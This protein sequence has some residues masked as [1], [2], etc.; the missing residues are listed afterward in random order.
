MY[1]YTSLGAAEWKTKMLKTKKPQKYLFK[2]LSAERQGLSCLYEK[3]IY[4][5][6]FPVCTKLVVAK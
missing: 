2:H 1:L 4:F 6:N 5:L 3:F